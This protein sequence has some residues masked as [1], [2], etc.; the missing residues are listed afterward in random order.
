M[1]ISRTV[2]GLS[3][4]LLATPA[5]ASSVSP[6]PARTLQLHAERGEARKSF[7]SALSQHRRLL[8]V[9]SPR[10]GERGRLAG[11]VHLYRKRGRDWERVTTLRGDDTAADDR[12]GTAVALQGRR[13]VVGAPRAGGRIGAVY[14]FERVDGEWMQAARV[15]PPDPFR[16]WFGSAVALDR[17]RIVVGARLYR[18]P[19]QGHKSGAAFVFRRQR[20]TW[21]LEQTLEPQE[22]DSGY[23]RAV[24]VRGP[25]VAVGL[26]NAVEVF[27]HGAGGWARAQRLRGSQAFSDGVFGGALALPPAKVFAAHDQEIVVSASRERDTHS[28]QGA[29]YV[30]RRDGDWHEVA[31]L[32]S[33]APDHGANYGRSVAVGA[34][35]LVVGETYGLS[36]SGNPGGAW[37]LP[38]DGDGFAEG[39]AL[40]SGPSRRFADIGWAVTVGPAGIAVGEGWGRIVRVIPWGRDGS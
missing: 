40:L 10:D 4:A 5:L 20:G 34:A 6:A 17:R 38:R 23:G 16:G 15:T 9:G 7:G 22:L 3:L 31:R 33:P 27:E 25:I 18:I 37:F 14:V 1:R 30:F 13:L 29:V 19:D 2:I 28:S 36:G 21:H 11:A 12:F 8:A 24:G 39:R 35:G 26:A 32:L